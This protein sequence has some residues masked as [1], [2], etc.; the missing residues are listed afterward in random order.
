[1]NYNTQK[2]QIIHEHGSN[3]NCPFVEF[4]DFSDNKIKILKTENF[5][6][7]YGVQNG[8]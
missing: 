8:N 2:V 7:R 1:M 5:L 3:R 6:K 4:R